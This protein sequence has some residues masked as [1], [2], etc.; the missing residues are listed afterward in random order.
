VASN[1]LVIQ[2]SIFPAKYVQGADAI[3]E[4]APLC[5][6]LGK[7]ALLIGDSIGA[8][9][10]LPRIRDSFE[11]AK[12]GLVAEEFRGECC[13]H[14]IDRLKTI[15]RD[16][17]CDVVIGLGGGKAMD[18]GKSVGHG[19]STR[20]VTVP[21]IA[22]TDAA[23][24]SLAVVYTSEGAFDRYQFFKKNPDLVLVDTAIIA[25]APVRFL[26]A[27]IGDALSTWFEADA[28]RQSYS[29][30][31]AGGIGTF[32]A[33]SLARL[34]YDTI[35]EFGV[36]ARRSCE[37]GVVTPALEHVVEANTL[38]SGLGFESAGVASAH[39]IHNGLTVLE[40][41][42]GYYHG[43]KVA[44]GVQAG[45]FLGDRPQAVID[46]VY[47][48]CESVGLPTTLA[49]IGLADVE[50]AQLN[51][52]ATAACSKGETIHNEPSTVTPERVYAS[53]VAADAFG[54]ARLECNAR[55]HI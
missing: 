41:T 52:V 34:C 17:R 51:Q 3:A 25:K 5:A 48:F 26:I 31:V 37:A 16:H 2:S 39:S 7:N 49:A 24:S 11:A 15:V 45:L 12:I 47:S 30:N 10:L 27:G 36:S 19:M 4:L 43:E 8:K 6:N 46:Q 20:V 40:E 14:E 18:T 38:L 32:A 28:C 21:T 13:D 44:I 1:C 54:R 42:H 50:P 33:Y 53:I 22:S 23:T 29:N 55:L 35:L 9:N